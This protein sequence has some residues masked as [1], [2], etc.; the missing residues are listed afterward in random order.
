VILGC[1]ATLEV[2]GKPNNAARV[3]AILWPL[4]LLLLCEWRSNWRKRRA[5]RE[6][7]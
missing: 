1:V 3:F 4:N 6:R 2:W 7:T 5:I